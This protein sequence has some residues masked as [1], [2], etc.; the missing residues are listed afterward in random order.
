[1]SISSKSALLIIMTVVVALAVTL[2]TTNA[3]AKSDNA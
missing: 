1:M 2:D 3:V